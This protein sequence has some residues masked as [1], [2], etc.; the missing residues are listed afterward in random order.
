MSAKLDLQRPHGEDLWVGGFFN[1]QTADYSPGVD[2]R[3]ASPDDPVTRSEAAHALSRH[4]EMRS[5]IWPPA[6]ACSLCFKP[7]RDSLSADS[8]MASR[9]PITLWPLAG[10]ASP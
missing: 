6:A 4:F 7:L 9:S 10:L 8:F 2:E 5:R 3:D 1:P